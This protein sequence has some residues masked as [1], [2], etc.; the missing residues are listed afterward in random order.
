[1]SENKRSFFATVPGLVTGLA[2]LLTGIVGLVTV[3]IQ[4]N[5]IGGDD[6]N[7]STAV[8]AG[9]PVTTS[10]AG[11]GGAGGT[12]PTTEGGTFTVSPSPLNFGPADP[13]EKTLTVKNTSSTARLSVQTPRVIGKDAERFSASSDCSGSL[14][15]NL[16]CNVRVTFAPSGPLRTYEA[17]VQIQ[18]T[19][20]P[21]G[22]EVKVTASTLLG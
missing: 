1:M 2:G 4:L 19:G 3:L 8:N 21:R 14:A 7:G 22:A 10:P 5:V 16:S 17:T 12:T 11:G 13:K 18:A 6:S 15:P 20:A 9:G